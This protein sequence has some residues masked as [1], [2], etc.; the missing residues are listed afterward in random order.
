MLQ[1]G[2]G[3]D[4]TIDEGTI[5]EIIKGTGKGKTAELLRQ[6]FNPITMLRKIESDFELKEAEKVKNQ[7]PLN[8]HIG[9]GKESTTGEKSSSQEK[10][11]ASNRS[12]NV[13][14]FKS[15]SVM[16]SRHDFGDINRSKTIKNKVD[17]QA[18]SGKQIQHMD[19]SSSAGF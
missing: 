11:L 14:S 9:A 4:K 1:L 18:R 16:G 12:Y 13:M 8:V 7:K 19:S 2:R 6:Q 10:H 15:S 5:A 3:A 17:L